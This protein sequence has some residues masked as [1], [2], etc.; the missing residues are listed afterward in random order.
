MLLVHQCETWHNDLPAVTK[1]S[2]LL[3]FAHNSFLAPIYLHCFDRIIVTSKRYFKIS[4][5]LQSYSDK[6]VV[7]PGGVDCEKFNLIILKIK[8][9]I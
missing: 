3:V 4:K 9:F 2:K 8:M 5:L 6:V 7:V 1:A